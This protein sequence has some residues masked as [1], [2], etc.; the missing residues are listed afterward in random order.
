MDNLVPDHLRAL[1]KELGEVKA[2]VSGHTL[3]LTAIET[4]LAGFMTSSAGHSVDIAEIS[5]R[6]ARIEKRLEPA[7]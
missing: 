3:R 6:V 5:E 7:E 1:R 4:H 2:I